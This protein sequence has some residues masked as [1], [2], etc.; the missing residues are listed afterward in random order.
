MTNYSPRNNM[1]DFLYHCKKED[2]WRE[3]PLTLL[4]NF[5]VLLSCICQGCGTGCPCLCFSYF[6]FIL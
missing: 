3:G 1:P 6:F 2:K 4:V 5:C